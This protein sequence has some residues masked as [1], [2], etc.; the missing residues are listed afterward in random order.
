MS[1]TTC[2]R[3]RNTTSSRP[4]RSSPRR[5]MPTTCITPHHTTRH[6]RVSHA[7]RRCGC[8]VSCGWM[9]DVMYITSFLSSKRGNGAG[10][11]QKLE[12]SPIPHTLGSA[13][14]H[15]S[16][17]PQRNKRGR[18]G[19]P[20]EEGRRPYLL[21]LLLQGLATE[22]GPQ[23]QLGPLHHHQHHAHQHSMSAQHVVIACGAWW[24]LRRCTSLAHV[25]FER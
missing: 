14:M 6:G 1:A 21:G 3:F 7:R 4:R 25:T 17:A 16:I 2:S 23:P 13:G 5:A 19:I 10:S 20:Q 11:T 24:R 22:G 15:P 12:P 18:A 9:Y 8:V